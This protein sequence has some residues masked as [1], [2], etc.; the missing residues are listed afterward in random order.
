MLQSTL[1][2]TYVTVTAC[3]LMQSYAT[4]PV[5]LFRLD[6][7]FCSSSPADKK[8]A[9]RAASQTAG[10]MVYTNLIPRLHGIY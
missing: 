9:A 2:P 7:L 5:Q 6:V 3:H 8:F 10:R 1:Q 4:G